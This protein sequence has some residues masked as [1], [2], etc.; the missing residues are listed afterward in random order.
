MT[1][2]SVAVIGGGPAGLMAAEVL[3][4]R[5]VAVTLYD[6]MPSVGRK[7]LLAGR[8]GL[9]L[10]HSED[11]TAFKSRY[12]PLPPALATSLTAH[13]NAAVQA[14][15][16]GLGIATFVGSSGRVF[17]VD[18]KAAPLLRAWLRRLRA[19]GVIF[20]VRHRWLGWRDHTLLFDTPD[21]EVLAHPT[22][23]VLALGGA[24]WPQLG[25]TGAWVSLLGERGM[26]IAPLQ[27]SNVGFECDWPAWFAHAHAGQPLKPVVMRFANTTRQGELMISATGL[28]GGLI[29][30]FSR[31][32]RDSIAR[33]GHA[34][35]T[36]D[37]APGRS[38]ER[39]TGDLARPRGSRSWSSHL[40][41]QAG[42]DA[43]KRGLLRWQNAD[44]L[45]Q[46]PD[47]L[48]QRIKA[49]PITLRRPR[50][51]AEAIST[52]GGVRFEQLN[53]GLMVKRHPGVFVA[54]EML[55]WEAPTGGYLLTA[56]FA[57]GRTAGLAAASFVDQV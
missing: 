14:W 24:S 50:P 20:K 10:T 46:G 47:A 36:L 4:Q 55:D 37:L 25:S 40:T 28:E 26:T 5:G 38:L 11:F 39:L 15:A 27:P 54:G 30:G 9:N 41:R 17:P 45:N 56:C 8:G 42:L 34:T 3:S 2:S 57:T 12:T 18:F 31:E 21:G 29:Y 33:D 13:D 1:P 35:L 52:A 43:T 32:I 53:D 16:E 49:L 7:L 48:A 51:L 23:T 44:L 22:A 19:A 6:S